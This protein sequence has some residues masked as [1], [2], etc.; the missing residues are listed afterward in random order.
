MK[1]S[2]QDI[3]SILNSQQSILYPTDTVYGIG[4]DATNEEAVK[5]I[6]H[7]KQRDDNKA[8][9]CLVSDLEMLKNY[10]NIIP[11]NA[12]QVLET[13]TKP[14]T[15]IY[16]N[17]RGLAKNLIAKDQTIAIRIIKSGF[18]HELIKAFGKPIVSTSANLSGEPT[19]K[20]F[21]EISPQILNNVD[22]IV[23]LPVEQNNPP[24]KILKIEL[25]GKITIIRA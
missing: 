22:Y 19:P 10:V 5:K 16:N 18:A 14:T 15:I 23:N 24:S 2:H 3:I 7:I 25:D 17:P 1:Q 21:D 11:K 8:L 9:I 4:C 13:V 6:Y 20:T 12:L